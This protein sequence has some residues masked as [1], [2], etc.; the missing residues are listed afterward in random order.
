MK[1]T[2]YRLVDALVET[3]VLRFEKKVRGQK[4]WTCPAVLA[5]LDAFA[6]RA[7]RRE[8]SR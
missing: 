1:A 7:G 3:K 6:K 8:F 4:V 2:T 5:A